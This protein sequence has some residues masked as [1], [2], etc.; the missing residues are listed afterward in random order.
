MAAADH[1]RLT[2]LLGGEDLAWLI[3]R[4]HR[5]IE[6]GESLDTSVTLSDSSAEQR[7]AVH[8]LLGRRPRPGAALT[9]SLT[10]VDEILRHSG[11]C[12]EGLAAAVIALTGPIAE[13][14]AAAAELERSW[15]CALAPLA[16]AVAERV[17]LADWYGRIRAAGLIRRLT[18]TPD[19]ASSLLADLA[20]IIRS[21]PVNGEPLGRFAARIVGDAHALDDGRPLTTLALGAAR[22]MADLPDGAGSEWRREVWAGVGLL[23]DDLSSTVLTLG[24]PGDGETA[25]GRMLGTWREVGQPALLTLR[26][27]VRDTPRLRLEGQDVFVCENPVVVSAAADNLGR[28]SRSLVCT[29]GQPGTAVLFLLRQLAKSGAV[30]RYHGDFDWGGLRIA[31]VVFDRLPVQPWHFDAPSYRLATSVHSG[32]RLTGT[33]ATASWDAN[34]GAAM[35][36]VGMRVEEE[37]VLDDLVDDLTSGAGSPLP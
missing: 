5:R 24:L 3:D 34:L 15:R 8:R 26:Q 2:R 33:P 32:K 4:V 35:S 29:G 18:G 19:S 16:A 9:V 17:E 6:R 31:N 14:A 36:A 11:A 27:L 28:H 7:A 1:E 25:T 23:R 10:R 13:R 20:T 37:A 22:A 21:L 12:Q 30:L